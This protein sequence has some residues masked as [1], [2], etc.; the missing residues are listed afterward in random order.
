MGGRYNVYDQNCFTFACEMAAA[1]AVGELARGSDVFNCSR[2]LMY[3]ERWPFDGAG[4]G[5]QRVAT[6]TDRGPGESGG[7]EYAGGTG[8]GS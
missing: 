2:A 8:G 1:C 4:Y 7:D 5:L 3:N 6:A